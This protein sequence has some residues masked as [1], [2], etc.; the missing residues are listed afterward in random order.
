MLSDFL[1]PDDLCYTLQK[2]IIPR[3]KLTDF[4]SMY[5]DQGRPPGF[6]YDAESQT[7][8]CPMGLEAANRCFQKRYV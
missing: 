2:E 5:S 7:I 8:R 4:E 3:I 1:R 6:T